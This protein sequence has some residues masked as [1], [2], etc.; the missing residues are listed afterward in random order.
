MKHRIYKGR[1]E[2][3]DGRRS[4][5]MIKAWSAEEAAQKLSRKG[6]VVAVEFEG[7]RKV[8]GNP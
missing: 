2:R 5:Y 4:T 7:E 8:Y 1:V 3:T 6:R